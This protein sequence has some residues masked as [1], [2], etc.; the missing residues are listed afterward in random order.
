M[1]ISI[2]RGEQCS[3]SRASFETTQS[4]IRVAGL[5]S[6]VP[7]DTHNRCWQRTSLSFSGTGKWAR[8]RLGRPTGSC[9]SP[10]GRPLE[11]RT[12]F[13]WFLPRPS[14]SGA[15][16][17]TKR[18]RNQNWVLESCGLGISTNTRCHHIGS[19]LSVRPPPLL[20][21]ASREQT[22]KR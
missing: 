8:V 18:E 2:M 5:T 21:C 4:L 11:F 10:F 15:G 20:Q 19:F 1:T 16:R 9:R 22:D 17:R 14:A 12:V 13:A 7:R 3:N 6:P